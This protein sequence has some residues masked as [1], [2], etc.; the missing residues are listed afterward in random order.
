MVPVSMVYACRVRWCPYGR[1]GKGNRTWTLDDEGKG[2]RTWTLDHEGK[3]K[4]TLNLQ[5]A[6]QNHVRATISWGMGM[7]DEQDYRNEEMFWT[8]PAPSALAAPPPGLENERVWPPSALVDAWVRKG[9]GQGEER[10]IDVWIGKAKAEARTRATAKSYLSMCG[11]SW[12]RW[13]SSCLTRV[14]GMRGLSRAKARAT[15]IHEIVL[16]PTLDS[17]RHQI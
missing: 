8:R 4:R 11:I 2:K 16:P 15:C 10:A 3:G 13:R 7:P 6:R 12:M 1:E 17:S 9:K 5:G 14:G